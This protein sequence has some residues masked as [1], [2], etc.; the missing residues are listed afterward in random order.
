MSVKTTNEKR[1]DVFKYL[2]NEEIQKN[3]YTN[4]LYSGE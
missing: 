3:N 4:K 2:F 1:Y